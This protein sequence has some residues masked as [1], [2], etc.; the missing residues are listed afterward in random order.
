ME[1]SWLEQT[2]WVRGNVKRIATIWWIFARR[3]IWQVIHFTKVLS[4]LQEAEKDEHFKMVLSNATDGAQLGNK[5]KTVVTIV[6]DEGRVQIT[7]IVCSDE[8][9]YLEWWFQSNY[10]KFN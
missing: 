10:S 7:S 1:K 3:D 6:N 5:I 2:M 4:I 9:I 8:P